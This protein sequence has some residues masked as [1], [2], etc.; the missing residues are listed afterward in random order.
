MTAGLLR[1]LLCAAGLLLS[2][3]PAARA[4][5]YPHLKMG[6]PSKAKEA[7]GDKDNYLMKKKYFAL[8]YNNDKGTPNWVSWRVVKDDLG[9]ARRVPFYPDPDLPRGFRHVLP[10]DYTGSG[11][12]RGH[13]CPHSDRASSPEASRATFVMTNMIPQAPNVNQEAWADLEDY[14]RHLVKEGH[15]LYIIAGPAGKGGIGKH[16]KAET[17]AEGKVTVPASCWKVVMVLPEGDDKDD[18]DKVFA[19]TR[20]IGVI[21]P[22]DETVKHHWPRYRTSVKEVEKLTGYTFF[23]KVP[24]E[25]INP[26]KE[27]VDEVKVREPRH[28]PKRT[29]K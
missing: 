6:N 23:D 9:D 28:R 20:I 1:P 8:S 19:R 4:D 18:I 24:A 10:N 5:E 3:L 15:R 21:M 14:L 7:A 25:T 26:L 13:V 16:G 2:L 17:I 27:K 11:F 22:N 12:D 29:D